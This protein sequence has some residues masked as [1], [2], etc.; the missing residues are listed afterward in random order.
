M[1]ITGGCASA[2]PLLLMT[3]SGRADIG[4]CSRKARVGSETIVVG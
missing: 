4:Q 3:D 1:V 2:A